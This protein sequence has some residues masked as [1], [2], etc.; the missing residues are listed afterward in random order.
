MADLI[1]SITTEQEYS[2]EFPL[3]SLLVAQ[4]AANLSRT[5]SPSAEGEGIPW[6]R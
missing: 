3:R 4:K 2:K 1:A 6:E 5:R